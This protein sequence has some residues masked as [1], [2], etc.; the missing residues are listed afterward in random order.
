MTLFTRELLHFRTSGLTYHRQL[1]RA[2]AE[3]F[4]LRV[5][6]GSFGRRLGWCT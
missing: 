2:S 5:T 4:F 6:G 3:R 1:I